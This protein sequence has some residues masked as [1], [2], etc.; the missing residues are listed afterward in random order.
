MTDSDKMEARAE[1]WP[2]LPLA[3]WKHTY[4][5]LHLWTRIVGKIRP[6]QSPRVNRFQTGLSTT[7]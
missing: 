3:E 7:R 6:V 4:A 1:V 5:T 2:S